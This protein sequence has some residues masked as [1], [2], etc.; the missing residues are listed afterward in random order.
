MS[1]LWVAWGMSQFRLRDDSAMLNVDAG[2]LAAENT[3]VDGLEA[4][5]TYRVR[6]SLMD[7]VEQSGLPR[8]LKVKWRQ[9]IEAWW[10]NW[11]DLAVGSGVVRTALSVRFANGDKCSVQLLTGDDARSFSAQGVAIE[12]AGTS[13][14]FRPWEAVLPEYEI[15]VAF[16]VTAGLAEG[17]PVE[18]GLFCEGARE[19]MWE[20]VPGPRASFTRVG[21]AGTPPVAAFSGS[22][23]AGD[24]PLDVVF[25][26]ASTGVIESW[27][28][29]FGDGSAGSC[30][31]NP[32]HTYVAP[33]TYSVGLTVANVAGS[34]EEVKTGYV[35][36]TAPDDWTDDEDPPEGWE[37][38]EE[39]PE[40]LWK[41]A[42][43]G[44]GAL[45]YVIEANT[46]QK[47]MM[48]AFTQR[49]ASGTLE[50]GDLSY[51]QYLSQ[52]DWRGGEGEELFDVSAGPQTEYLKGY[53]VRGMEPEP[54]LR[55]CRKP[56]EQTGV[57]DVGNAKLL[58]A[59]EGAPLLVGTG[60][61]IRQWQES[62]GE[63]G[64]SVDFDQAPYS[65]ATDGYPSCAVYAPPYVV[66]GTSKGRLVLLD[67]D[68]MRTGVPKLVRAPV[69]EHQHAVMEIL[70]LSGLLYFVALRGDATKP[71]TRLFAVRYPAPGEAAYS[72]KAVGLTVDPETGPQGI[73]GLPAANEVGM[74]WHQ[75]AI[76]IALNT[77]SQVEP[78]RASMVLAWSNGAEVLGY[79]VFPGFICKG[80]AS[81]G[82]RL[83][84]VGNYEDRAVIMTDDG[85]VV[86]YKPVGETWDQFTSAFCSVFSHH[87]HLIIGGSG[88]ARVWETD[89]GMALTEAV[90]LAPHAYDRW[91]RVE[92]VVKAQGRY[93]LKVRDRLNQARMWECGEEDIR[94][95]FGEIRE[96]EIDAG[97]RE[98]PKIFSSV[99]VRTKKAL[100]ETNVVE[101]RV[102]GTLLGQANS[103]T[104]TELF[105]PAGFGVRK[106]LELTLRLISGP[107]GDPP[108]LTAVTVRYVP[109][110]PYKRVWS[111]VVKAENKLRMLDRETEFRSGEEIAKDLWA[112]ANA[113][114]PVWFRDVDGETYAV[115]IL[116][117]VA[118]CPMPDKPR[119]TGEG[120]EYQI[121]IEMVEY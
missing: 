18:I 102:G 80:M 66:V 45:G 21:A 44:I 31:Q 48:P 19:G 107:S 17:Q 116:D 23:L 103:G 96:S 97:M 82:A 104:A 54:T 86:K 60:A 78:S 20:L 94:E 61:T 99:T 65:L 40:K 5:T 43:V 118:K 92:A 93:H 36:V 15:E 38:G 105:F 25:S 113:Q 1:P 46:Y 84:L 98:V 8:T 109:L 4:D 71:W 34:D 88:T 26:D 41:R 24:A 76:W 108:E 106:T 55:L 14:V 68:V 50:Y 85:V 112:L 2:W 117:A 12:G 87:D 121:A 29:D 3:R 22:P 70:A 6:F 74:I 62:G 73:T 10:E 51:W 119:P 89:G 7:S 72:W 32:V 111:F 81:M 35:V 39:V 83:L 79:K 75:G 28:W 13:V 90:F 101:V 16:Q 37:P 33:G 52:D 77:G 120:P 64:E 95:T 58:V 100:S 47:R 57:G 114:L 53:G 42:H 30:D 69:A 27:M 67:S 91:V 49:F 115:M 11:Q 110:G 56:V 63:W 9:K 59:W